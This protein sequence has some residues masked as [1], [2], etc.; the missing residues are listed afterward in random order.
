MVLKRRGPSWSHDNR[1]TTHSLHK[2]GLIWK[3]S[4]SS[5]A[6]AWLCWSQIKGQ[7]W[8]PK[9]MCTCKS[10][11]I[12]ITGKYNTTAICTAYMILD[13]WLFLI[14]WVDLASWPWTPLSGTDTL[15]WCNR[16][17]G[18]GVCGSWGN[19]SH[20]GSRG[21][22]PA[23]RGKRRAF[24]T[25]QWRRIDIAGC[26]KTLATTPSDVHTQSECYC[27]LCNNYYTNN[28]NR[29]GVLLY[30]LI[31]ENKS[32]GSKHHLHSSSDVREVVSSTVRTIKMEEVI[33]TAV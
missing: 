12:Y 4:Q 7:N 8:S 30:Y 19:G 16:R 23:R 32:F 18:G 26:L 3:P 11:Q 29:N 27:A 2:W 17:C 6:A 9:F 21:T 1:P 15:C 5:L 31:Q 22:L 10:L 20:L 14:A 33:G 13:Y 25:R 24:S 28:H